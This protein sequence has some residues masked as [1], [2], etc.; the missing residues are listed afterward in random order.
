MRTFKKITIPGLM[1]LLVMAVFH[2]GCEESAPLSIDPV[3]LETPFTFSPASGHPGQTVVITGT[4]LAD[5]TSVSFSNRLATI[6]SK[7]NTEIRVTIPVGATTGKIRLVRPNSVT[8][9]ITEFRVDLVPIPNIISFTPAIVGRNQTVT[10]TGNLLAEVDSVYV[11]ALRATIGARTETTLSIT[12]PA[13]MA[14]GPI[15]M[16]YDFLTEFGFIQVREAVS[17]TNLSLALPVI[18]SITPDISALNVGTVLTIDGTMMDA[19]TSVRFGTIVATFT[20]VSP[21][22]LT[23][24]VPTGATTG[25]IILTVPDG[26]TQS[27]TDFRV[28]LPV[29]TNFFPQKGA[30]IAGGTRDI[31]LSGTGFDLVTEARIGT[32]PVTIMAQTPTNITVRVPG[33]VTGVINL[34]TANGIVGTAIPFLITGDFWV[35]DFDRTFTPHRFTSSGWDWGASHGLTGSTNLV[36]VPSGGARGNFGSVTATFSGA[37]GVWPRFWIRADGGGTQFFSPALTPHPGP[38]RFLLY[39]SSS[40][41]VFLEFDLN[42]STVP[43]QM[44]DAQ[45]NV[46][47]KLAL[48]AFGGDTP[49]GYAVMLNVPAD[50]A[51][52]TSFRIN[53]NTMGGGGT[54]VVLFSAAVPPLGTARWIPNRNRIFGFVF[55]DARNNPALAGQNLTLNIDNVRF[56]IE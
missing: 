5:V 16:F 36:S 10:I 43:I 2:S 3:V 19:V 51:T 48:A 24:T 8:S 4:G 21:T 1:I 25:R 39:T 41:G 27:A 28:V 13:A 11:G 17:A 47:V 34:V 18:N 46:R 56:R 38:D 20:I 37:D 23:V 44:V 26:T 53:T 50:P 14:T 30:E 7:T 54:D 22:R 55:V 31:T 15:R 32:T 49:W 6:V 9:S 40:V 42:L 45:G 52:W 29:I 33:N 35:V 12:T